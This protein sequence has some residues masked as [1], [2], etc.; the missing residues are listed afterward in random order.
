MTTAKQFERGGLAEATGRE[1]DFAE[2]T[3]VSEWVSEWV[4]RV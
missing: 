1:E 2:T 3:K 4:S